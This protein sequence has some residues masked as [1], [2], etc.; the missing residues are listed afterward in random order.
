MMSGWGTGAYDFD[1]DGLKEL[2]VSVIG[3]PAEVLYNVAAG[4]GSCSEAIAIGR[5]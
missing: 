2:L 1:N 4:A 3:E 5:S